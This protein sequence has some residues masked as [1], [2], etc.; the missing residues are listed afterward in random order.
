MRLTAHDQVVEAF[1]PDH[2]ATGVTIGQN[3]NGS[4]SEAFTCYGGNG[5]CTDF[6]N[7]LVNQNAAPSPV[8]GRP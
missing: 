7:S 3:T 2:G 1:A 6:G 8:R 4:L 5:A